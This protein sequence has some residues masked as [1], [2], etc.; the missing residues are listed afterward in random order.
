MKFRDEHHAHRDS[1]T[2]LAFRKTSSS[3]QAGRL[4]EGQ[5]HGAHMTDSGSRGLER[6]AIYA[7]VFALATASPR[8]K[9]CALTPRN[10]VPI[11][12]EDSPQRASRRARKAR[13]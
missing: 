5:P 1:K 11:R 12:L 13:R 6:A 2:R 4:V 10:H 9:R 3:L 7:V 8:V